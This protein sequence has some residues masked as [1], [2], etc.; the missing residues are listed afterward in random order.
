MDEHH[1]RR[2]FRCP[3]C[4]PLRTF[5]SRRQCRLNTPGLPDLRL[6]HYM[7]RIKR[8]KWTVSSQRLESSA[9]SGCP[10]CALVIKALCS[11]RPG[12]SNLEAVEIE[13]NR[14]VPQLAVTPNYRNSKMH[15]K[16]YLHY[17]QGEPLLVRLPA[18]LIALPIQGVE[19]THQ[20]RLG[21]A[22]S[23]HHCSLDQHPLPSISTASF[24]PSKSGSGTVSRRTPTVPAVSSCRQGCSTSA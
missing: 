15:R 5:N 2:P 6:R 13:L 12:V 1:P 21:L 10:A 17:P 14:S 3:N 9:E 19:R 4:R 23:G 18:G 24:E 16:F 22:R 20:R 7:W 8:R 11:L